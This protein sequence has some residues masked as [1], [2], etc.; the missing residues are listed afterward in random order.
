[1]IE[2][3]GEVYIVN[4]SDGTISGI[5]LYDN[6]EKIA[7]IYTKSR[8]IFDYF[9]GLKPFNSIYAELDV[10]LPQREI[11]DVYTMD[12][13]DDRLINYRFNHEINIADSNDLAQIEHFMRLSEPRMNPK[14]VQVAYRNGEQCFTAKLDNE[15]AG[16]GWVSFIN[17]I[18]RLHSFYVQPRYRKLGIG[19]DLRYARLLWLKSKGA[20]SVFSEIARNN[21]QSARLSLKSGMR[22]F[23]LVYEYFKKI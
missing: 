18:G 1:V 6:Y 19:Q 16:V 22:A 10:E 2:I 15:I 8:A 13:N 4:N 11:Y 9:Y 20:H 21:F 5:F 3:D 14:W 12:L 23:G 7:S 17:N